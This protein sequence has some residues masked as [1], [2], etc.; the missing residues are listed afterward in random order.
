VLLQLTVFIAAFALSVL[1]TR[2]VRGWAVR[3]DLLDRP[4]GGRK[5]H[6]RA[7]PRVGG[8]GIYL[9]LA[10]VLVAVL[11]SP[12][13]DVF[14]SGHLRALLATLAG[15]TIIFLLGLADDVVGLRARTKFLVQIAVALGMVWSGL[16]ISGT[17]FF[18]PG[19][20]PAA[21]ST[22]VTVLWI[23]LVTNSFNLIDGADGVAP[24][25]ALFAA[26]AIAGVSVLDGSMLAALAALTLAGAT[27]GFLFFNFPPASI[28][29]GDCGSLLLGFTI[30]AIGLMSAQ[31][32]PTLL[33][34]AIPVVSCG[35]PL[36]DTALAVMRRYLRGEPL[37]NA[38]R[39]HIH[40]RL[41]DF[42]WSPRRVAVVLY[43]G[44]AAF[45]LL[46]MMLAQPG[47]RGDGVVLGI[48]GVVLWISVQ[49]LRIPELLEVG[50]IVRRGLHQRAVI[51]HNVRIREA[52]SRLH[53]VTDPFGLDAALRCALEAGEFVRAELWVQLPLGEPLLEAD[54]AR[55][56]DGCAVWAV[57]Q[58]SAPSEAWELRIPFKDAS[59]H[60][61]G[62][63]S[64]WFA[65]DARHV[66]TDLRLVAQELEPQILGALKRIEARGCVVDLPTFRAQLDPESKRQST[67]VPSA[68]GV[69]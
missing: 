49:R 31:T 14:G 6:T 13:V 7:V 44:C 57:A 11:V 20:M 10:A 62:R 38:D 1:A 47:Y 48:A 64:F 52:M 4:D 69:A 12:A 50:R 55:C 36:L 66:L 54:V 39:G 30:A 60:V 9:A 22:V 63:L 28:F 27:L 34:V 19:G 67:G 24:G 58:E 68:A 8:I 59:G 40:H 23:V 5:V 26:L 61:L 16:A 17:A 18:G 21:L 41:R 51:G 43:A 56:C 35:L 2:M 32:Q 3:A 29:L 33:A 53:E 25:A 45:A 65:S 46:S 42:G 37:F 15:A